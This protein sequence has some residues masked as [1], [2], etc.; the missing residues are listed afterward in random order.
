L[1][2]GRNY[3]LKI[4]NPQSEQLEIVPPFTLHF[5]V[6][7]N[8]L[9]TANTGEL[10]LHNLG[11][12]TRNKIYKDYFDNALLWHVELWSGY[13]SEL[14]LVLKG[15][16]KEAYSYK[17]GT[18]WLTKITV[19]DGADAF[20]SGFVAASYGANTQK[21]D[22]VKNTISTL[23]NIKTGLLG[24]Y[25]QGE[26]PKRASVVFGPT[27]EVLH[28]LTDGHFYIDN[29]VCHV[30]SEF[31][32]DGTDT[33][34]LDESQ[35]LQTPQRRNA[36]LDLSILFYPQARVSVSAVL[37][38][39]YP[40]YNGTYKICGFKHDVLISESENGVARTDLNL[41]LIGPNGDAAGTIFKALQ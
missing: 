33:L 21:E 26:G 3:Q 10:E 12:S 29:E 6:E 41:F 13:G 31:E 25:A 5:T 39:L 22:I 38:S 7:R 4:T 16:I 19:F 20:K 8:N 27:R 30:M 32:Y 24:A 36:T 23:P 17:Q 11:P 1:K 18:E 15:N 37:K 2:L 28:Y 35:L 9:A 14:F 40:I 34:D